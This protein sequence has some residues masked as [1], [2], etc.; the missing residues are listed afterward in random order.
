[1]AVQ[2]AWN[3][4]Q[5]AVGEDHNA[6]SCDSCDLWVHLI[7]NKVSLQTYYYLQR[8]SY[9]WY[10]IKCF[11]DLIPFSTPLL[12]EESLSLSLSFTQISHHYLATLKN[13]T[14]F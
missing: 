1:M 12:N 8:T 3:L 11:K 14:P 13:C 2:F 5:C 7:C 10:C 6:I 4:C 9:A